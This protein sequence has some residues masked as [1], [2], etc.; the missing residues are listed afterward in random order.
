MGALVAANYLGQ[1]SK[2]DIDQLAMSPA[3][4]AAMNALQKDLA[5]QMQQALAPQLEA[6][7]ASVAAAA[8]PA[9]DRRWR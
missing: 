9:V 4:Q 8:H 3:M 1:L 2:I 7:N 6:M 5:H